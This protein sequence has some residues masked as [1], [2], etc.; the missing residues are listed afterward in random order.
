MSVILM[1]MWLL[2]DCVCLH[3]NVPQK[4]HSASVTFHLVDLGVGQYEHFLLQLSCST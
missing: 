1:I 4:I 2:M 3:Q